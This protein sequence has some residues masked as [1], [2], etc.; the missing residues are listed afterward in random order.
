MKF[1]GKSLNF[2]IFCFKAKSFPFASLWSLTRYDFL[3]FMLRASRFST[4]S[5][6]ELSLAGNSTMFFK[7]RNAS[8]ILSTSAL[9]FMMKVSS[10]FEVKW[11]QFL[12]FLMPRTYR[13]IV[14]TRIQLNEVLNVNLIALGSEE[15]RMGPNHQCVEKPTKQNSACDETF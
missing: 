7:A 4:K 13:F 1:Q 11:T 6:W 12:F 10:N 8:K 2:R 3:V 9:C 5:T 15:S 14:Q